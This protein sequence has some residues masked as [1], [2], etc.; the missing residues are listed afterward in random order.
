MQQDGSDSGMS[1]GGHGFTG[2]ADFL[3]LPRQRSL[4]E[5][6][7]ER[8]VSAIRDGELKP[9][10]RLIEVTLATRMGVSR[11]PLREALKLLEA[12]GIVQSRRGRGTFVRAITPREIADMLALRAMLEG[13]AARQCALSA[14][15]GDIAGLA[16][17]HRQL[18]YAMA[19]RDRSRAE[20]LDW[21]FHERVCR[22]A[23][24]DHLFE[25]WRNLA[26]LLMVFGSSV[27]RDP[28]AEEREL[29][30]H[31]RYLMALQSRDADGAERVFRATILLEGFNGLRREVPASLSHYVLTNQAA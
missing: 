15:E 11:A 2:R 1:A 25:A 10:N 30:T 3:A 17:M 4:H 5:I 29:D 8:L 24:N 28:Q 23:G 9:G 20:R 16:D 6:V 31:R 18:E 12:Q 21:E 22:L 19:A 26:R 14:S 27:E 7:A 13:F